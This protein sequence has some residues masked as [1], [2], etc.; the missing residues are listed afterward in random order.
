M[1][2]Y[3]YKIVQGIPTLAVLNAHGVEGWVVIDRH[4]GNILMMRE[5]E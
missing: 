5:V 3:E 2:S 1:K 4:H